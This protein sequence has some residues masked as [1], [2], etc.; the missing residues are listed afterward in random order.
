MDYEDCIH[1]VVSKLDLLLS[2][3]TL[4]KKA[5]D[6]L[7]TLSKD[8]QNIWF[9]PFCTYPHEKHYNST[10]VVTLEEKLPAL[11]KDFEKY[12]SSRQHEF[13]YTAF[14]CF[15]ENEIPKLQK[16]VKPLLT[17]SDPGLRKVG[18]LFF[19]TDSDAAYLETISPFLSD[20]SDDVSRMAESGLSQIE[21]DTFDHDS[22]DRLSPSA[23][24]YVYQGL[25]RIWTKEQAKVY[26]NDPDPEIK[27]LALEH[28]LK[29]SASQVSTG[30]LFQFYSSSYAPLKVRALSELVKRNDAGSEA[31]LK[32]AL[33][34]DNVDL[35]N[36]A[37]KMVDNFSKLYNLLQNEITLAAGKQPDSRLC[38]QMLTT[39]DQTLLRS[40]LN[41][42][43]PNLRYK[44]IEPALRTGDQKLRQEVFHTYESISDKNEIDEAIDIM[45]AIDFPE[46]LTFIKTLS[47]KSTVLGVIRVIDEIYDSGDP[48]NGEYIKSLFNSSDIEIR[49]TARQVYNDFV[50]DFQKQDGKNIPPKSY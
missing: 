40:W 47:K 16:Y 27:L 18:I 39:S 34:S 14:E 42:S 9:W 37:L 25:Q 22:A 31:L 24:R 44:A 49:I 2:D 33:M 23:R 6:A 32:D 30:L 45:R 13:V 12:L 17:S 1:S 28:I 15:P 5:L 21:L 29:D 7:F 38:S 26:L 11:R 41:S 50:K 36:A 35:Q 4:K 3:P 8:G 46:R 19:R 20:P 48:R 43:N 10:V